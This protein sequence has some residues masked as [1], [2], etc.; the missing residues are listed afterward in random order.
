M[1]Q[2]DDVDTSPDLGGGGLKCPRNLEM[3]IRHIGRTIRTE[4]ERV[5]CRWIYSHV[6]EYFSAL[7]VEGSEDH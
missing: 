7:L 3:L 4:L 5:L 2:W 1:F 6:Q